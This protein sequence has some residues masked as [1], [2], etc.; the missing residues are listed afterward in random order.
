VA[1]QYSPGK[2]RIFY[3]SSSF[4]VGLHVKVVL[5]NSSLNN[6]IVIQLEEANSIKG[7]YYFDHLFQEGV[8]VA[9][10][11][12]NDKE[13]GVQVYNIRDER[14]GSFRSPSGDNVINV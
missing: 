9:Y 10:F 1:E 14:S 11:Y 5:Y 12:E 13:K 8:Y 6:S 3:K 4:R 7:L 2:Q